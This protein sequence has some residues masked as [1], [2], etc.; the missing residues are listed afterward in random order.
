MDIKI[1]SILPPFNIMGIIRNAQ[2]E[3]YKNQK[4]MI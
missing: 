4:L 1:N 2:I 3:T